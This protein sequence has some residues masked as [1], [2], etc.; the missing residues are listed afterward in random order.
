MT[1]SGSEIGGPLVEDDRI[2]GVSFTGSTAVGTS[3]ARAVADDLKRV[4]CEM[5][6]KNPRS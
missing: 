4:Q 6:G 3:V 2:D 1:G 5:G